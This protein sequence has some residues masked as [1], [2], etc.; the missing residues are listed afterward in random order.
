MAS[1]KAQADQPAAT[2]RPSIPMN[3]ATQ[4]GGST[5]PSSTRPISVPTSISLQSPAFSS[6]NGAA[7]HFSQFS[8]ST[9]EILERLRANAGNAAGTPAFEA[10]KAEVLQSYV[11]SD[12]LPTP[13]PIANSGRRGGRSGVRATPSA[14]KTEISG[15][16]PSPTTAATP[17]SARGSGRGRGRGRGGSRGGKRKRADSME[18]DNDSDISSSYTPLPTRT[19]SGRSVNKPVTFVPTLPEPA[20][21]VKR[22]RSTKTILLAQ[23]KVCHRGTDPGNNRIVFCDVCSTAYHQYCH[24][25]PIE[26]EVVTVLEKEWLC[27]PCERSKRSV[28]EGTQGLTT[29]EGLTIEQKRAYLSTLPQARL[30]P[31]LLHATI[32]HPELPIFPPNVRDLL[33]ENIPMTIS[34]PAV[35][36]TRQPQLAS[37]AQQVTSPPNGINSTTGTPRSQHITTD[38]SDMDPAEAQLLG[39]IRR[40][41]QHST[42]TTNPSSNPPNSQPQS[43]PNTTNT[44]NNNNNITNTN[45]QP[46]ALDTLDTYSDGYDTDPPAHYPKAGNGLARTLRPESEDLQWLVDDNFEVFSHGWRGDGTG[47]GADSTVL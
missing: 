14:L 22:R 1:A 29:G 36:S 23:C 41:H 38:S 21:G 13:P 16:T 46:P 12:K 2:N 47:V 34:Q 4:L 18:S 17:S 28:I 19:K 44:I 30:I 32:R 15:A 43:K 7:P 3:S 6:Q 45:I 8:A 37:T 24:N 27:G 11:T 20:P 35:L 10:K 25:P 42:F 31:L 33:P 39:E 5:P 26:N 40:S 9:T